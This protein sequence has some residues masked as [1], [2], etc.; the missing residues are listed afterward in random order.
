MRKTRRKG[1][2]VGSVIRKTR[3]RELLKPDTPRS[4]E[5]PRQGERR[6]WAAL[7]QPDRP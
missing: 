2:L 5:G 3:W 6:R 1:S 4:R 7:G